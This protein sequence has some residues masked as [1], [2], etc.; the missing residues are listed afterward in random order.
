MFLRMFDDEPGGATAIP[1]IDVGSKSGFTGFGD[2]IGEHGHEIMAG[3]IAEMREKDIKIARINIP[4]LGPNHEGIYLVADRALAEQMIRE[5]PRSSVHE[6]LIPVIGNSLFAMEDTPEYRQMRKL[7]APLL[8]LGSVGEYIDGMVRVTDECF[9]EFLKPGM[10]GVREINIEPLCEQ[11]AAKNVMVNLTPLV[12]VSE[13]ELEEMIKFIA[14]GEGF[15]GL[16]SLMPNLPELLVKLTPRVVKDFLNRQLQNYL[17]PGGEAGF[18]IDRNRIRALLLE[19]INLILSGEELSPF[20]KNLWVGLNGEQLTGESQA[21]IKTKMVDAFL[22][23]FSAGEA[24]TTGALQ[25]ITMALMSNDELQDQLLGEIDAALLDTDKITHED[26]RKMP[27]LGKF[28]DWVV[29]QVPPTHFLPREF[30]EGG[31][32][33]DG[34]MYKPGNQVWI[35]IFGDQHEDKAFDPKGE[36]DKNLSWGAGGRRCTGE[37]F[38]KAEM[39]IFIIRLLQYLRKKN[40]KLVPYKKDPEL[41]NTLSGFKATAP[42]NKK[43]AYHAVAMEG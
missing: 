3:M 20:V 5:F 21:E 33:I 13:Q 1:N 8:G 37:M 10:E 15:V 12:N 38:A 35:A 43:Y 39:S 30:P 31:F 36:Y 41:S 17:Y 25:S 24:T 22:G 27:I 34:V 42:V 7:L 23:L 29:K 18:N 11:I 14:K 2:L 4:D 32:E 19:N 40:A 16:N 28:I 6:S 9:D 26:L